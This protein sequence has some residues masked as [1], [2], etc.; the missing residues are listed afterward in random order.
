MTRCSSMSLSSM[1][2]KREVAPPALFVP[3]RGRWGASSRDGMRKE[4]CGPLWSKCDELVRTNAVRCA[5]GNLTI[6]ALAE[7]CGRAAIFVIRR[8]PRC[9]SGRHAPAQRPESPRGGSVVMF[10]AAQK[11]AL[12]DTSELATGHRSY[13][14]SCWLAAGRRTPLRTSSSVRAMMIAS[15]VRTG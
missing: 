3:N 14:R 4:D 8:F 9:V 13:Q 10:R 1:S 7:T 12:L 15:R 5:N 2:R 6:C 11:H